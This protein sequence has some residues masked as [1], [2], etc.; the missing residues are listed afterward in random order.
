[1]YYTYIIRCIDGS[2]YTGITNDL[3]K[4]MEAHFSKKG[5]KYTKSHKALKIEIAWSCRNKSFASK[6]EYYIK[7][8]S[9][10]DKEGLVSSRKINHYLKGIVDSRRYRL[11]DLGKVINSKYC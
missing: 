5:A 7:G 11:V 2:L 3:N 6:L 9:K 10:L 8:L 4:R 1:M